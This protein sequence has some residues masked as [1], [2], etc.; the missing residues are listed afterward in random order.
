MRIRNY[1]AAGAV[2]L[3]AVTLPATGAFASVTPHN[4]GNQGNGSGTHINCLPFQPLER[5]SDNYAP[6]RKCDPRPTPP[7]PPANQYVP[8]TIDVHWHGV[9]ATLTSAPA[10]TSLYNT[11]K[12]VY[13]GSEYFTIT[14]LHTTWNGHTAFEL[15]GPLSKETV[16][17]GGRGSWELT[18]LQRPLGPRPAM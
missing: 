8:V 13:Q 5:A 18:A 9:T 10:F 17:R 6:S 11:E 16:Y 7:A 12:V 3:A 4:P 14:D 1:F 2:A 15:L